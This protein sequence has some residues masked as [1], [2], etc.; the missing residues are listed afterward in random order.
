MAGFAA[1]L[2][3][4]SRSSIFLQHWHSMQFTE[5]VE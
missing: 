2:Q 3:H 1:A 5:Q 4:D